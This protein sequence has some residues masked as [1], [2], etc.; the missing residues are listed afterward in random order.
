M[1]I[2]TDAPRSLFT[3]QK[4]EAKEEEDEG[5]KDLSEEE[6]RTRIDEY[7]AQISE[8]GMTLVSFEYLLLVTIQ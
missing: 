2:N 6:V 8:N 7:N 4:A 5:T 3:L 1:L